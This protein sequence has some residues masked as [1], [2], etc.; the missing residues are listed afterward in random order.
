[1]VVHGISTCRKDVRDRTDPGEPQSYLSTVFQLVERTVVAE[2]TGNFCF[3]FWF[4]I[5]VFK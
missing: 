2:L 1:M 3:C 5:V 4:V